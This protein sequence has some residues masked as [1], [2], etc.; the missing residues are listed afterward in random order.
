MGDEGGG[1]DRAAAGCVRRDDDV[2]L[3]PERGVRGQRLGLE[4]V[5]RGAAEVSRAQRLDERRLVERRPPAD[6]DDPRVA[7]QQRQPLSRD[8]VR[9]CGGPGQDRDQQVRA[10]QGRV[11]VGR[12]DHREACA[13]SRRVRH[14]RDFGAE[15]AQV[16]RQRLR[17]R[18]E[19]PD[20]HARP[21]ERPERVGRPGGLQATE[22]ARPAVGG[23]GAHEQVQ[24][25]SRRKHE[26]EGVLGDRAVVQRAAGGDLD[27][28]GEPGVDH[29]VRPGRESLDPPQPGQPSSG[30]RE[31]VSG[32]SPHHERVRVDVR[33]RDRSADVIGDGDDV[34]GQ[35]ELER[36]G[37]GHED[38]ERHEGLSWGCQRLRAPGSRR[39]GAIRMWRPGGGYAQGCYSSLRYRRGDQQLDVF[40]RPSGRNNGDDRRRS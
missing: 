19:A 23:L 36:D 18:A 15:E 30:V 39:G 33:G 40:R 4:D 29:R 9:V 22:L 7:R 27:A 24:A 11:Q 8:G 21:R 17:D 6:V 13:F 26:G 37:R 20:Q 31:Q 5:E 16:R 2:R 3:V 14:P 12:R 38:D 32:V 1:A 34:V 35:V 28:G 10:G 25:T